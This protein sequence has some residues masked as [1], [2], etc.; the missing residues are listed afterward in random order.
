MPSGLTHILLTKKLQDHLPDGDLKNIFAYRSDSLQVGSVAPDIPY[1]SLID[2][3]IFS[4]QCSLA[5]N[6]HYKNTKQIP[7]RSLILLKEKKNELDNE[8]RPL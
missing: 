5:D 1:A 7:L 4:K 8:V 2:N 3:N 6:F